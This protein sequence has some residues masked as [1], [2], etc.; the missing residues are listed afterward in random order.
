[1]L[2]RAEALHVL[3]L[4]LLVTV[5]TFSYSIT[6]HA[7]LQSICLFIV[8][9]YHA[10]VG[11][12]EDTGLSVRHK[13]VHLGRQWARPV[14]LAVAMGSLC[15]SSVLVNT[16]TKL[17]KVPHNLLQDGV[18]VSRLSRGKY[19]DVPFPESQIPCADFT[20]FIL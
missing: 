8:V 9:W 17:M 4:V 19:P 6:V 7:P 18:G 13:D 10:I 12:R 11:S 16:S 15:S 5:A 1:M 14:F 2:K 20:N 3:N